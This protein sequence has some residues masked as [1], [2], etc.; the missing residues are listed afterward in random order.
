VKLNIFFLILQRHIYFS[1]WSLTTLPG[2][3]KSN[4][5]GSGMTAFLQNSRSSGLTIDSGFLY[6]TNIDSQVV[7]RKILKGNGNNIEVLYDGKGL[8]P[9]SIA[10]WAVS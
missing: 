8:S 2:I 6:F 1:A 3:L 10:V 5:D 4:L 7:C 9:F